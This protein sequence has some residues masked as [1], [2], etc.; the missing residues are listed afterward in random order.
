MAEF[1]P[2]CLV[3][4]HGRADGS[5]E[6]ADYLAAQTAK[7]EAV[8]VM[9]THP[10]SNVREYRARGVTY[11]LGRIYE[12]LSNRV[13][14]PAEFVGWQAAPNSSMR[15]L[16]A[17][18]V[19]D[20]EYP[21]EQNLVQEGWGRSWRDGH[22][23]AVWWLECLRLFRLAFPQCRFGVAGLSPGWAIHNVRAE[24]N[25]FM[26]ESLAAMQT[27]DFG[28]AHCYQV[29]DKSDGAGG[30][31]RVVR[32]AVPGKPLAI[33]EFSS[34]LDSRILQ[35]TGYR[36]FYESLRFER[37]VFA[38]FA[39]VVSGTH[40]EHEGWR[41]ENGQL[42][43]IPAEVARRQFTAQ[44]PAPVEPPGI[45]WLPE[46]HAA[47]FVDDK[48]GGAVIR[49]YAGRE[50]KHVAPGTELA[51]RSQPA[52]IAGWRNRVVVNRKLGLHVLADR[53]AERPVVVAPPDALLAW[54]TEYR[55]VTQRF[56]V[57]AAFYIPFGLSGHE[58]L[59][60]RASY[61][62]NI[63]A[64]HD[65]TV[66]LVASGGAYG[67]QVRIRGTVNGKTVTT[68]YA[69]LAQPTVTQGQ[70]VTRRQVIGKADATGN[71]RPPGAHHLH[72]GLKVEGEAPSGYAGY[73]DPSPWLG[74]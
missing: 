53:I 37:D 8:K 31:W 60:I 63:F 10:P 24:S 62:S 59:D 71:V 22:S 48:Y 27:A 49:D 43:P 7:V 51:R 69:H 45:V 70:T 12:D 39:F 18:G 34:P 9:T 26:R 68:V 74:L 25:Q 50:Y 15:H 23:F 54:P 57:N 21:N 61:N 65:G 58:G 20:W 56:G 6:A 30:H 3:G 42:T 29:R 13:V 16:V 17:E 36:Q 11:F 52:T 40:F 47:V 33:T 46:P 44:P 5:N 38:A 66:T 73:Q 28:C 41:L 35:A 19:L 72:F 64:A 55:V 2:V 4:V 32:A 67:N 14:T 1:S